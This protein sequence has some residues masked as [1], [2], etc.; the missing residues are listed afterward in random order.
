MAVGHQEED[1]LVA[2]KVK[3]IS[4]IQEYQ[5]EDKTFHI[6]LRLNEITNM[7]ELNIRSQNSYRHEVTLYNLSDLEGLILALQQMQSK[8]KEVNENG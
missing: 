7:Q 6:T 3:L 1:H 2:G 8:M 5:Y 4:K